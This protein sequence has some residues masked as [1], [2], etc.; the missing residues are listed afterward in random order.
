MREESRSPVLFLKSISCVSGALLG[1]GELLSL[2]SCEAS[3]FSSR[4]WRAARGFW[5]EAVKKARIEEEVGLSARRSSTLREK[6]GLWFGVWAG[7][8]TT[9]H[10]AEATPSS[11]TIVRVRPC[12]QGGNTN[13]G[14]LR[15]AEQGCWQDMQRLL[16]V[17]VPTVE[18]LRYREPPFAGPVS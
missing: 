15:R 1:L 4:R 9:S 14:R 2:F 7:G 18:K 16:F 3:L 12:L 13:P 5:Q 10:I 8:F 17:G 6:S 11:T